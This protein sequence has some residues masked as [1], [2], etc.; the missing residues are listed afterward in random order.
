MKPRKSK[1]SGFPSPRPLSILG[2][3]PPELDEPRLLGMQFQPELRESLAQL[4]EEPLGVT[5]V[6]EAN[7][8]VVSEPHDDHVTVRVPLPPLLDP[9]VEDVVQVDVGEQRRNRRSLRCSLLARRPLPVLDAPLRSAISGSAAGPACPLSGARGTSS[10]SR[11]RGWSKKS[12]MSASSTQFT[13][14]RSI[15]TASAS[16][17]S[18]RAAPRPEPVG[19][20]EKVLLVDGVQH[21]DDGAL[22]DL[23]L[24]RWRCRAAAA[25]RPPSGCTPSATGFARYAPR[26]AVR[27]SP[28]GSPPGPARS[29]PRHAVDPGRGLRAESRQYAARRRSRS[30]WCRSAVNRASL[31]LRAT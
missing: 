29:A 8:E 22:D 23:V 28:G 27:C 6:L 2:G 10:A 5:L 3:E 16:S 18:M 1:V 31:S 20:A 12:R 7:D 19:E 21:L 24:Q 17:A 30:T 13:F 25:A 26:A 4:G 14:F 9:Q 11:D 15:P